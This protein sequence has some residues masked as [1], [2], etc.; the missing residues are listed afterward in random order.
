[1]TEIGIE[2]FR[3]GHGKEYRTEREEPDNAVPD[4]EPHSVEWIKREKNFRITNNG[5]QTDDDERSLG[6]THRFVS[7]CDMNGC[8]PPGR[9]G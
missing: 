6:A 9:A 1:M 2:C 3:A 7:T 5:Q 8:P 4:Q